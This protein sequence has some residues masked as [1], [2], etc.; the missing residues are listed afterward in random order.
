MSIVTLDFETYYSKDYTLSKLTTEAYVN[1]PQFQV[2]GFAYS[3]DGDAPVWVTGSDE[4]IAE[5][6]HALNLHK[7][8]VLAHNTAFDGAILSWRYGTK[9]RYYLDTLSMARPITGLTVGG[10]LAALAQLY[11]LGEKGTEVVAAKGLRR[12]DFSEEQLAQY[13]AYCCN[14]VALT[15]RVY[16]RLLPLSTPKEQFVI[17]LL[18]RMYCDPVLELDPEVLRSHYDSQNG[19]REQAL[20][21]LAVYGVTED[22]IMSNPKFAQALEAMGVEPPKK[23][24]PTTGKSTYAFA[25]TDQAMRDLLN[26]SNPSVVKAVEV[27]LKAKSSLEMTRADSL[28]GVHKRMGKL[29]VPLTYYGGH[30]GRASGWDSI[31]L[32]NLPRGGALRQSICAPKGHV[33]VAVDSSQ[34]EARMT[35]WFAGE[36][37]LVEDFANGVDIYSKFATEIYDY[38]VD[39]SKKVERF[40]G[41]TCI[42]GLGYGM[43]PD[44]FQIALRNGA[45]S[46]DMQANECKRI[47]SIYRNSYPMIVALWKQATRCL[48]AAAQGEEFTLGTALQLRGD[49][50]GIH[51][52]NG[53]MIRYPNLKRTDDQKSYLYMAQKKPVFLHGP[54]VI[55]N[56]VQA[57]AR[58]VVFDQMCRISQ[59]LKPL[60]SEKERYRVVSTVHDEVIACVPVSYSDECIAM[61][62]EEMSKAP[63][64]A[65]GLPIACEGAKGETYF[66]CK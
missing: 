51:L 53:M 59:R 16:Q 13:G 28:L 60:D 37:G 27:R 10:S 17:D 14:D 29:P 11:E 30:T 38:P 15:Y 33:L 58:I 3:V 44:K 64:W 57:L 39:K 54:K 40:V 47:V 19:M 65:K 7:H 21:E 61:M 9:P 35:A 12:E 20:A 45:I 42:L 23:I 31:N 8:Y 43:G 50:E 34:I 66:D 52:P 6:I 26:H 18:L 22:S 48:Q 4:H 24:S 36:A 32:Q 56:V 63:R 2:I 55:E 49:S 25:K 1:D 41:K 62:N 46:V 5:R